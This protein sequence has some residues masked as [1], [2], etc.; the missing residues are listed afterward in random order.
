M[1]QLTA[2]QAMDARI[3][4]GIA[5][6]GFSDTG[7]YTAPAGSPVACSF[8]VDRN[9][10][11]IGDRGQVV[12]QHVQVTLF[13]SQI[14]RPVRGALVFVSGT[15]ETFALAEPQLSDESQ[16]RWIVDIQ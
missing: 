15:G 5:K 12:G 10:V 2:L 3:M 16:S 1:S 11:T 13:I 8:L 9:I 4:A 7:T 6:A 14:A